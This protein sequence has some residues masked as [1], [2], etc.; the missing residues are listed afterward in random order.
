MTRGIHLCNLA[1]CAGRPSWPPIAL[2]LGGGEV[3]LGGAEIRVPRE[4]GV[5]MAAPTM[6]YHYV[7]DHRY[8][9]PDFFVDAVLRQARKDSL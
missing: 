4:D 7:V 9:P 1:G 6:V 2:S 8:R 5:E 3:I